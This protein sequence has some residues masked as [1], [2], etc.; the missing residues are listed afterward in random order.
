MGPENSK[1]D[2]ITPL[3]DTKCLKD[4]LLPITIKAQD[5]EA[6]ISARTAE[7]IEL[8]RKFAGETMASFLVVF[9]VCAVSVNFYGGG[10]A[11]SLATSLLGGLAVMV[12]IFSIGHVSGSHINPTVTV[13]QTAINH[14]PLRLAPMYVSAHLVGGTLASLLVEFL[15]AP[16]EGFLLVTPK[17]S[18]LHSFCA[19]MLGGFMLLF[20]ASSVYTDSRAIGEFA[21]MA[22]G[23]AIAIDLAVIGPISGGGVNP[24]RAL[25]PAFASWTFDK[26]VWVFVAG[27]C[28]GG[29]LGASLYRLLRK[30]DSI[31]KFKYQKST[32]AILRSS[33][34]SPSLSAA[35]D[36]LRQLSLRRNH[37]AAQ[38]PPSSS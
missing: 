32:D 15:C 17:S 37:A 11:T 26:D 22:V 18:V 12:S 24:A 8:L 9:T 19:E 25:G 29:V 30:G 31:T 16:E 33:S 4:P 20:I 6:G 5:D 13:A 7:I 36:R 21:G 14:F 38:T 34:S 2:I 10:A 3:T 27:P 1:Y 28:C 23:T 35:G